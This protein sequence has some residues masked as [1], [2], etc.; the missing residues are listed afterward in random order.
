[1]SASSSRKR[2]VYMLHSFVTYH[3][4]RSFCYLE[5]LQKRL[6]SIDIKLSPRFHA[7]SRKDKQYAQ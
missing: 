6:Y 5:A 1:M 3:P 2:S 7:D 4:I